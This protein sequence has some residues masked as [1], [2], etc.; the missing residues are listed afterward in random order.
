MAPDL[1]SVP[2]SPRPMAASPRVISRR[3][4][5]QAPPAIPPVSPSLNI[6]PSNQS[7]VNQ[8]SITSLP[9][10]PSATMVSPVPGD[11]T[12][13]GAGPGPLRHPR[14][15]TAA[16]L[17]LQLEKEQEAVV[18]SLPC[19]VSHICLTCNRLTASLASYPCYEQP[20]THLLCQMHL[21]PPQASRT[22]ETT[23]QTTYF[24]VPLIPSLHNVNITAHRQI[25]A[26]APSQ[27]E[28]SIPLVE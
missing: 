10:P 17:H 2:A 18:S 25:Q 11:N 21:Q 4:S 8:S 27:Q 7:A 15:L 9:T 16:D 23:P 12:G 6:L 14:P 5:Q 3:S 19:S 26:Y 24:Q 1:N 28:V 13:V 22:Q 20:I